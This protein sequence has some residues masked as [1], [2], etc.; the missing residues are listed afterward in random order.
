[1]NQGLMHTCI[2]KSPICMYQQ[3]ICMVDTIYII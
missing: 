2:D 1:M 3:T